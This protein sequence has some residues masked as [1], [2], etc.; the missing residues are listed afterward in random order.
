MCNSSNSLSCP[1]IER[2]VMEMVSFGLKGASIGSRRCKPPVATIPPLVC[3]RPVGPRANED[4]WGPLTRGCRLGLPTV[5]TFGAKMR[6][7]TLSASTCGGQALRSENER[8]D[9]IGIHQQRTGTFGAKMRQRTLSA[10]TSSEQAPS[11]RTRA[12]AHHR[13][14]W[15]RIASKPHPRSIRREK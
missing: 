13:L 9:I 3:A 2:N 8:Q 11:A 6:R 5:G 1:R 7:R 15:A 4:S 12:R 10:S 14:H